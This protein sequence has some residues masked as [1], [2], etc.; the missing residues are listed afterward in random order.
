MI[1]TAAS[2]HRFLPPPPTATSHRRFQTAASYRRF[3]PLLPTAASCRRF[4]PP[5]P[6]AASCRRFLPPPPATLPT[7]AFPAASYRHCFL[8]PLPTR[9]FLP[10]LH[11]AAPVAAVVDFH[12]I[13]WANG[14]VDKT[15]EHLPSSIAVRPL[16]PQMGFRLV[17]I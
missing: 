3:L 7:A 8:P 6:A 13:N 11:T 9:R 4:L 2:Y 15:Y 10:P 17:N 1:P 5:L 14:H 16:P 12:C